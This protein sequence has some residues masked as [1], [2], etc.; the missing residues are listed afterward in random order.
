MVKYN[1][2]KK[3]GFFLF[4]INKNKNKNKNSK[5]KN[6]NNKNKNNK[7]KKHVTLDGSECWEQHNIWQLQKRNNKCN[8]YCLSKHN[9]ILNKKFISNNYNEC[10]SGDIIKKKDS[11]LCESGKYIWTS[12][13]SKSF[14]LSKKCAGN[15]SC[16]GK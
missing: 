15:K 4:N 3:G 13:K 8:C 5:N 10:L 16:W 9:N 14:P 1:K 11:V 6:K 2:T 7:N 12:D